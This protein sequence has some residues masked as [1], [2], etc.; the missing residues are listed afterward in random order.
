[1]TSL[2]YQGMDPD[3]M[4]CATPQRRSLK[5]KS[6]NEH[7][8]LQWVRFGRKQMPLGAVSNTCL[9]MINDLFQCV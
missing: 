2:P 1:M 6:I 7:T 9:Y 5:L 3:V 8:E 4:P